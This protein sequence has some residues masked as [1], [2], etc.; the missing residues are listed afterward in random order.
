MSSYIF[1]I[2]G[3]KLII[4]DVDTSAK[5]PLSLNKGKVIPIQAYSD[6]GNRCLYKFL[7]IFSHC[8]PLLA[9]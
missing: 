1:C 4:P 7:G 8:I 5:Y 6:T 9:P 2:E 3:C